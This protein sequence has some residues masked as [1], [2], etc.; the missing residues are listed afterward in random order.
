MK[1]FNITNN[2]KIICDSVITKNGFKH[3]ATLFINNNENGFKQIM[4]IDKTKICYLNRTW[5]SYQYESVFN[6][7]LNIA[8]KK[9]FIDLKSINTEKLI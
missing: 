3:I 7:L 9:G 4:K 1:I 5:E 6:K 2:I 8:D